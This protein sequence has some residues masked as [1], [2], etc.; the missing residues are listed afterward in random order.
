MG[1]LVVFEAGV[2]SWTLIS[3]LLTVYYLKKKKHIVKFTLHMFS[4]IKKHATHLQHM[5]VR[6]VP[7]PPSLS[8]S[9]C[10]LWVLSCFLRQRQAVVLQDWQASSGYLVC[11]CCFVG[12]NLLL[13][14][15]LDLSGLLLEEGEE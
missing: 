5:L 11:R 15:S 4:Q 6:R 1:S 7:P 2:P 3:M 8:A 9:V 12:A 10:S 13:A 14:A